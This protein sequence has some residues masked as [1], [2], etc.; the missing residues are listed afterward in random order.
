VN[1]HADDWDKLAR[2]LV[3]RQIS[4]HV[5]ALNALAEDPSTLLQVAK[6]TTQCIA[7]GRK[8]LT[9]G[10][11]GSA[12]DAQH[13]VVELVG[14]FRLDR[15]GYSAIALTE[16]SA[17]LTAIA[18]DFDFN[19]V[20]SRQVEALGQE[21]DIAIGL[22]TSG[23]SVNVVAGLVQAS[24]MGMTTVAFTGG[25]GGKMKAIAD[26]CVIAGSADTPRIQETHITAIHILCELVEKEL[27]S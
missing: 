1:D 22:S 21:G 20:F 17:N 7:A 25:D 26:F 23:N 13:I 18:N 9:F 24:E 4:D 5:S 11:G 10:N 19:E 16:N 27:A 8:I 12:S 6:A 3:T 15:R 2:E 14:R